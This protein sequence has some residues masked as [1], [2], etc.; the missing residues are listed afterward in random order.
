MQV[1]K[2][3]GVCVKKVVFK[4]FDF[5]RGALQFLPVFGFDQKKSIH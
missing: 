3:Q 4:T 2:S 1:F 5:E